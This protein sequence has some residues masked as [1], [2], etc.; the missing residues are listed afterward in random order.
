MQ[1]AIED[2]Q[3]IYAQIAAV[4]FQATVERKRLQLVASEKFA[5]IHAAK[6][7]LVSHGFSGELPED[8]QLYCPTT[9]C[10]C[11]CHCTTCTCWYCYCDRPHNCYYLRDTTNVYAGADDAADGADGAANGEATAFAGRR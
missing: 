11:H 7:S 9:H 1:G 3:D 10:H 6:A 4:Q 5:I 8:I 2:V